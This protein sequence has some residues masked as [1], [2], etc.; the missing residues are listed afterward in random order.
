[1]NLKANLENQTVMNRFDIP[2][3]QIWVSYDFLMIH[4]NAH[5]ISFHV[6]DYDDIYEPAFLE[7]TLAAF[8][9]EL[10]MSRLF[11]LVSAKL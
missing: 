5:L 10:N 7:C 1:M 11:S 8:L 6:N 9:K 4:E 3:L 2:P